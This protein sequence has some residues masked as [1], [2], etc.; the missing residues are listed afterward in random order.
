M[1][2]HVA[3][4]AVAVVVVD[5]LYAIQSTVRGARVG[6]AFIDVTFTARS[7]KAR[8]AATLEASHLI[9]TG[10]VVMTSTGETIRH[11]DLT[12]DSKS[13]CKQNKGI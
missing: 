9:Y 8:R 12:D 7:H 11:V 13:T 4:A 5:Q 1:S 2:T 10:T 6:E 3:R